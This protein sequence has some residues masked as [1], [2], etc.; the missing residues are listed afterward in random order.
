MLHKSDEEIKVFSTRLPMCFLLVATFVLSSTRPAFMS[1]STKAATVRTISTSQSFAE[2]F[3]SYVRDLMVYLFRSYAANPDQIRMHI[4]TNEMSL[5]IDTAIPC[6]LIV[7]ELVTNTLKYA[8]PAGRRGDLHV[9]LGAE[10]DG[11]LTLIVSDNGI[12]LPQDFDWRE[13]DS[14]GLQLVST[15]S[16]QLHGTI[17]VSGEGGTSYK[18]TFPG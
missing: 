6:G 2:S 4:D 10:D 17:E 16:A 3:D 8:F 14:L 13:S 11:H 7:S 1:T 18:I 12:G 15:L 9:G 5:G